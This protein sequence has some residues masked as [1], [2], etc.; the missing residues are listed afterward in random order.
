[1]YRTNSE[2]NFREAVEKYSE[3][4]RNNGL[5]IYEF[6]GTLYVEKISRARFIVNV[7]TSSN[8][9]DFYDPN[10]EIEQ[11]MEKLINNELCDESKGNEDTE[12]SEFHQACLR[13]GKVVDIYWRSFALKPRSYLYKLLSH[14]KIITW[15]K[16]EILIR[17]FPN[18]HT[19]IIMDCTLTLLM[20]EDILEMLT[21]YSDTASLDIIDVVKP[22][23][24][25]LD[26]DTVV[27]QYEDRFK[28][29]HW[30][31]VAMEDDA[32]DLGFSISRD[33]D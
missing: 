15:I 2:L 29:L 7:L 17:L 3:T 23:Q 25:L 19:F 20:I 6:D 13:Y 9:I 18:M 26:V 24:S 4:Y 8:L 27:D 28:D 31:I 11:A 22:A 12:Q 16:L 5:F 32:G 33:C 10:H 1:M 30:S 21:K 14:E